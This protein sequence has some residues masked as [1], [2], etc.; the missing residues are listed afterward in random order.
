MISDYELEA[1]RLSLASGDAYA[2]LTRFLDGNP[3]PA[4][5]S[6]LEYEELLSKYTQAFTEWIIFC[7][8]QRK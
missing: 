5:V 3:K 2:A 8:T 1:R 4:G 7:E 6:Y